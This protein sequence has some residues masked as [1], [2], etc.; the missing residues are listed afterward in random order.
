MEIAVST[1]PAHVM[2]TR[3]K[4]TWYSVN[5]GNWSDPNTWISNALDK[6]I[7]IMPRPGDDVYINHTVT[8][9]SQI[10]TVLT[11][12]VNNLYIAGKLLFPS[13]NT[14][15]LSVNGDLQVSGTLDMSGGSRG[16][17]I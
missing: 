8:L 2:M 16:H 5:D 7:V 14:M 13:G 9:D 4:N 17:I 6:R 10:G 1:S 12:S 11:Y 15:T 3:K